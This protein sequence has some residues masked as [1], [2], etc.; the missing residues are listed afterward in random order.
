[1]YENLGKNQQYN[2]AQLNGELIDNKKYL[3]TKIISTQKKPFNV[4]TYQSY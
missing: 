1:M 2:K 4:L 3:K